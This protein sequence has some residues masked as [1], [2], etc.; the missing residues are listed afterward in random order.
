[1][2]YAQ[3]L[4]PG[5]KI[6]VDNNSNDRWT[7]L[8]KNNPFTDSTVVT[9]AAAVENSSFG[10]SISQGFQNL[11]ALVGAPGYNLAGAVDAPGAVYT[12]VK[13]Q[14]NQFEENVILQLATTD[15]VGYGNAVDIGD[16]NWAV[17]GA[18]ASNNNRG[19]AVVV[20]NPPG[21]NAFVQ[22]QLLV[23]D[24]AESATAEDQFG[25]A[26]N[27]S[28]DEKWM[29][30]GA[31]GGNRVYAYGRVDVQNQTVEYVTD[32]SVSLFNYS[33]HVVVTTGDQLVVALNSVILTDG[34][35]YT[36]NG[37]AVVFPVPPIQQ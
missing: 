30:I 33:Q 21:S 29:Y 32:G 9:P 18:S 24:P 19:Y 36:A 12:F 23:I 8:E 25:Y 14:Q 35:D 7:V 1:L 17:V 15:T 13:N 31:P 22:Q 4:Q 27:M 34:V 2:S 6:W 28:R 37:T 20:Y 3:Q 16:Q 5:I 11:S 10:Y 26:V